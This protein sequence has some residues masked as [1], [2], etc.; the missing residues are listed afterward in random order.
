MKYVV[1]V[2]EHVDLMPSKDGQLTKTCK[3]NKYQ[4]IESHWMVLKKG[5]GKDV[6]VFN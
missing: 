5:K 2:S 3:G 1:V 4:Q 6:S